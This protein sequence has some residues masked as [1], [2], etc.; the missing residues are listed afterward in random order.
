MSSD[1]HIQVIK[2]NFYML[3]RVLSNNLE[4]FNRMLDMLFREDDVPGN[5]YTANIIEVL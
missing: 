2:D 5:T 4:V 3:V 1:D